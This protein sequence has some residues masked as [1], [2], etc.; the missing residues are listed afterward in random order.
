M[1]SFLRIPILVA[2]LACPIGASVAG[3]QILTPD[4]VAIELQRTDDRIAEARRLISAAPSSQADLE[5]TAAV[6]SQQRARQLFI[7]ARLGMALTATLTA[8]DHANRAIALL[9]S[10]PDPDQVRMQIDR[11]HEVVDR[12]RDR[13]SDCTLERPRALLQVATRM[14]EHA[15]AAFAADRPLAALQLAM[16][17]RE[18]AF[19]ALRLCRV[20]D[21]LQD[22]IERALR[23]TDDVLAHAHDLVAGRPSEPARAALSRAGEL[24]DGAYREFRADHLELALRLTQN[25][26]SFA[27]RAIRLSGGKI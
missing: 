21:N 26:R 14:V 5:I 19:L 9:R 1:K 2:L 15:D 10:L 20:E 25:A 23:R 6:A 3:A 17:A 18:R 22:A 4:R 27:A 16:G 8:R 11:T 12:A 24:Q 13:L 7:D